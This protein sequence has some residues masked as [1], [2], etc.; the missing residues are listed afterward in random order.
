MI[1]QFGRYTLGDPLGGGADGSVFKASEDMGEGIAR[2]VAIKLLT[3][4][5][6]RD[7]ARKQKFLEEAK[8]LA[9]LSGHPNIVNIFKFG[10]DEQQPWIAMELIPHTLTERI[11]DGPTE[12]SQI[13]SM[14][15]QVC[16]GLL[17]MH[18]QSPPVLHND[19]KP[20]NLLVDSIQHYKITDFGLAA[21]QDAD[22]T[23][24]VGTVQYVA[25]EVLRDN[26]RRLPA[27]DLY[28][29]GFMAYE[30][31]LGR[32]AF[33]RQLPGIFGPEESPVAPSAAKW[34][35]WH[36]DPAASV[37]RIDSIIP[38]FPAKLAVLIEKLMAKPIEKRYASAR[39]VLEDLSQGGV[40][41][42]APVP[43][44]PPIQEPRKSRWRPV[45]AAALVALVA[46]LTIVFLAGGSTPPRILLYNPGNLSTAAS[47]LPFEGKIDALPQGASLQLKVKERTYDISLKPDGS[48]TGECQLAAPGEYKGQFLLTSDGKVVVKREVNLKRAA[49]RT[50]L[51]KIRTVPSVAQVTLS[52]V[53]EATAELDAATGPDGSVAV[54]VPYGRFA[55]TSKHDAYDPI[56]F[57]IETGFD[58]EKELVLELK[59]RKRF[60]E[61]TVVPANATV[62]IAKRG[63][64]S[65]AKV[66]LDE[67]GKGTF[68]LGPGIYECEVEADQY[69][70]QKRTFK[71]ATADE[72]A[73][74]TLE[75]IPPPVA[76]PPPPPPV[77]VK[78]LLEELP[79][80]V[81]AKELATPHTYR[82]S[83][84][85]LNEREKASLMARLLPG[86]EFFELTEVRVDARELAKKVQETLR[87]MGLKDADANAYLKL[88]GGEHFLR[89]SFKTVGQKLDAEAKSRAE[90][91]VID[92]TLVNV[93]VYPE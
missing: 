70:A 10:V 77:D 63:D 87:T 18:E 49:P 32:L 52:I 58:P 93:V 33:R 6:P 54:S 78:R 67:E 36:C 85:V 37:Q 69:I 61:V 72:K 65:R 89:V 91:F 1:R 23:Y 5:P 83:G 92:K 73:T 79:A 56:E 82:L 8:L 21:E 24:G 26:G 43:L 51:L 60:I 14:I 38:Q 59:Q 17:H 11:G 27:S 15:A 66:T 48:F 62:T 30:M 4:I 12:P 88:N 19:L 20:S 42:G 64:A 68:K 39:T 45:V 2:T 75:K 74:F 50:V 34:M 57:A 7:T 41:D 71:I 76:L 25:P 90:S 55:M 31:A 9:Q 84:V 44:P 13:R 81:S 16:Q 28:A 53:P 46:L 3:P 35:A 47:R 86:A 29:L 40:S 22:R 80:G